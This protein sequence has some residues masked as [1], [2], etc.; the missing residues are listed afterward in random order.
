MPGFFCSIAAQ[1]TFH[2]IIVL[3]LLRTSSSVTVTAL[4]KAANVRFG[5][6]AFI[7]DLRHPADTNADFPGAR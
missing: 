2:H 5:S 1:T 6:N 3:P 4:Q 7:Q